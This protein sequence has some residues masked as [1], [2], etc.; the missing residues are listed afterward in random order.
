MVYG[1]SRSSCQ[2]DYQIQILKAEPSVIF[3]QVGV[4]YPTLNF[5]HVRVSANLT[6]MESISAGICQSAKLFKGLSKYTDP[7]I[8]HNVHPS[9]AEAF[10][11]AEDGRYPTKPFSSIM[12][13]I[14]TGLESKCREGEVSLGLVQQIFRS[15]PIASS[16]RDTTHERRKKQVLG[17]ISLLFSMYNQYEIQQLSSEVDNLQQ[18]QKDIITSIKALAGA[19]EKMQDNFKIMINETKQIERRVTLKGLENQIMNAAQLGVTQANEQVN[20]INMM[21]Q[22]LFTALSGKLSPLLVGP[23]S[24][25]IA[26]AN[27]TD[28]AQAKGYNAI[29]TVLPHIF[30]LPSSLYVHLGRHIVDIIVH[31]PLVALASKRILY[32]RTDIPFILPFK[33][34]EVDP[35]LKHRDQEHAVWSIKQTGNFVGTNKASSISY[36]L[37]KDALDTC[38]KINDN[39]YCRHLIRRRDSI[40]NSCEVALYH[41]QMKDIHQ[42]CE[43]ELL[44]V[45]ETAVSIDNRRTIIYSK[46]QLIDVDCSFNNG[47][48]TGLRQFRIEGVNE[49]VLPKDADCTVST[50]RHRWRADCYLEIGAR[51]R[52]LPIPLDFKE[53]LG[54]AVEELTEYIEELDLNPYMPISFKKVYQ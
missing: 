48:R 50:L 31:V 4:L 17:A 8:L 27:L 38:T 33:I 19:T 47:S 36:E 40:Q 35:E 44:T 53:M 2:P 54:A 1:Y 25:Q 29:S 6:E 11:S 41:S 37:P 21:S 5:A 10:N 16:T 39:W 18:S 3:Q 12:K 49:A 43:V 42:L 45:P 7:E 46:K 51:P 30:E 13:A 24:L 52:V 28:V 34:N 14:I 9:I 23:E 26:L 22:G 32:K 20:H 15:V